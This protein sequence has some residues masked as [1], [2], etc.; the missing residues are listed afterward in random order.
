[1]DPTRKSKSIKTT[2]KRIALKIAFSFVS[3]TLILKDFI[4]G[5]F[6]EKTAGKIK[7]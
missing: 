6:H 2:Q 1:M 3:I 7:E 5:I 4:V